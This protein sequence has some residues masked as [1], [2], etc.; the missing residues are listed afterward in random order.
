VSLRHRH[1]NAL[2]EAL[3]AKIQEIKHRA[4]GYPN[5]ENVPLAMLSYCG[6]L[7]MS[8]ARL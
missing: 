5:R 4:L 1:T 8:H 6:V 7:D 2:T 3:N